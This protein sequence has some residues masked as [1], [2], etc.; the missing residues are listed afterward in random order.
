MRTNRSRKTLL[1]AGMVMLSLAAPMIGRADES[2]DSCFQNKVCVKA[3]VFN[4][5]TYCYT[6]PANAPVCGAHAI[7]GAKAVSPAGWGGQLQYTITKEGGRVHPV[8]LFGRLLWAPRTT[9]T[10]R[11]PITFLK[12][13]EAFRTETLGAPTATGPANGCLLYKARF[14]VRANAWSPA[15][16]AD[17]D[18]PSAAATHTHTHTIQRT[19]CAT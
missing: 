16:S 1:A 4:L 10:N 6:N 12:T 9:I 5:T 18:L 17:A 14:T 13:N 8:P 11:G 15:I 7:V 3:I 19:Y 2:T